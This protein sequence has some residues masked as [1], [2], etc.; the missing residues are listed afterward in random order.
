MVFPSTSVWRSETWATIEGTKDLVILF[1]R[2]ARN[3]ARLNSI[4]LLGTTLGEL[5]DF[6]PL[7]SSFGL[8]SYDVYISGLVCEMV[9]FYGK[10]CYSLTSANVQ[11]AQFLTKSPHVKQSRSQRFLCLREKSTTGH[12][13]TAQ[14]PLP[15]MSSDRYLRF[16]YPY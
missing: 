10:I 3:L 2:I 12:F 4:Y 15:S 7:F 1:N 5:T 11:I 9:S 6:T 8:F 13:G 16:V 14:R